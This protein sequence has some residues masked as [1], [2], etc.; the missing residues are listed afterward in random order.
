M[1]FARNTT[2]KLQLETE[3]P[4]YE[5]TFAVDTA[6]QKAGEPTTRTVG[7]EFLRLER[8]DFYSDKVTVEKNSV[9]LENWRYG[10]WSAFREKIMNSI[11][12]IT[13]M[14][15]DVVPI[16]GISLEYFDRFDAR[17]TESTPD[18]SEIINRNSDS[19]A[20]SAFHP[21]YPWHCH[22]GYFKPADNQTRRLFN[23]D[24][25]VVDLKAPVAEHTGRAVRIR[26]HV[27]DSF[28]QRGY[29][30]L[31]ESSISPEMVAKRLDQLHIES[32]HLLETILTEDAAS[33]ISL[34]G[35]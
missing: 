5:Q 2:R 3:Q 22:I 30:P 32:K 8:Q 31:D 13:R 11:V 35:E 19:L 4:I 28:N 16:L 21:T 12:P 34:R 18:C 25:D 17:H 7:Y 24:V 6:T 23:I 27:M 33:A 9:S 14:Y 29:D 26:T 15:F 20:K 10:R 1:D